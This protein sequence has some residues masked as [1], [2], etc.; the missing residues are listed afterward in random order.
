MN[1]LIRQCHRAVLEHPGRPLSEGDALSL[2]ELPASDT[3]D[4]LALGQMSRSLNGPSVFRCG[5]LNAK[6]GR[7]P[8]NCAFCAQSAHYSTNAPVFGLATEETLLRRAEQLA[9]A[10][11][12]RFGIVTSGSAPGDAE[13]DELCRAARRIRGEV[14]IRLCAS[15]GQL[16]VEQ[17]L[18]LRE[19]GFESYHHN[20]ETAASHFSKICTTHA[21]EADLATL[22]A[23]RGAGLRVCSGGILGLGESRKQRVELALI[24]AG[25]DVDSIPVNFLDPIPGTPLEPRPLLD[26]LEALRSVAVFRLLNPG[27]DIL[28]CGGRER[29]L[30]EWQNLVFAAG[31]NGLMTGNYLSTPGCGLEDD[32]ERLARM[33]LL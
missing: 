6:S 28:I 25:A 11:V 24:L 1:P 12:F 27:R 3:L 32:A 30:G 19:A 20:L 7:C 15:L 9:S 14:G 17:G 16:T 10:G 21:Y 5:I 31:A 13:L 2:L 29:V 4:L 23:A 22:A 26:P 33:G 8:E 18:R